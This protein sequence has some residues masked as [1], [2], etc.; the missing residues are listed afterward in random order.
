MTAALSGKPRS[1]NPA[2]AMVMKI[3]TSKGYVGAPNRLCFS[4]ALATIDESRRWITALLFNIIPDFERV[5]KKD[6]SLKN[7]IG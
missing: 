7:Y 2:H 4:R 1:L 5:T 6:D 3:R